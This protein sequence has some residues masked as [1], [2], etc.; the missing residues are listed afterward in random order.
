MK[1]KIEITKE[2]TRLKLI[3][4]NAKGIDRQDCPELSTKIEA[5]EW[6]LGL[7]DHLGDPIKLDVML[8]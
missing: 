5:L 2:I 8:L 1:T 4:N 7:N 6:V 3:I